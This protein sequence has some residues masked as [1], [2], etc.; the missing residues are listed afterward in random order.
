MTLTIL[1]GMA[2]LLESP[3]GP[4]ARELERVGDAVVAATKENLN[5]P[6]DRRTLNPPPGPPKRRTG[7]LLN[8]VR[9]EDARLMEGRL[10]VV[11][12]APA[13]HRGWYYDQ[14]LRKRGYKFVDL[15]MVRV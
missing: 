10:E 8:S 2:M 4:V 6:Y 1:P 3:A 5:D 13:V 9:R 7:D 12:V 14:E 15:D 11:C